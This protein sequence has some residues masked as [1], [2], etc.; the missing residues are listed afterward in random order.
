MALMYTMQG[1]TWLT[2]SRVGDLSG[3]GLHL[4]LKT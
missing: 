2:M 3:P 4:V 1:P